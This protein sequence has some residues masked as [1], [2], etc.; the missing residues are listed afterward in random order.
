MISL[1]IGAVASLCAAIYFSE[2]PRGIVFALIFI[3]YCTMI[4]SYGL[5][6]WSW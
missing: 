2:Q 6:S 4:L 3:G 5:D 1:H